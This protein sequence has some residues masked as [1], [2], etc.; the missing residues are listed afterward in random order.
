M[1]RAIALIAMGLAQALLLDGQ[2]PDLASAQVRQCPPFFQG[3]LV[4]VV[5]RP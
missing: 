4:S 1:P 2:S 3:F 5:C